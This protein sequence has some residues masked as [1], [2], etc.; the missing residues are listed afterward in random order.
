MWSLLSEGA[1]RLLLPAP[2]LLLH[3]FQ[4]LVVDSET[5]PDKH[6]DYGAAPAKHQEVLVLDGDERQG[7]LDL[8]EQ[9]QAWHKECQHWK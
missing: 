8:Q 1:L 5:E 7:V 2:F 9:V 6:V 3:N 4:T